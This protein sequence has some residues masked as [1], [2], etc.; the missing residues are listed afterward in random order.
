MKTIHK[1]AAKKQNLLPPET[2][3]VQFSANQ[4]R[5]I[6][7]LDKPLKWNHSEIFPTSRPELLKLP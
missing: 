7:H 3:A 2:S 5:L 4:N 6:E 1:P